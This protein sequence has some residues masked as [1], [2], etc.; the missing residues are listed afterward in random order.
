MR[1]CYSKPFL[2]FGIVSVSQEFILKKGLFTTEQFERKKIKVQVSLLLFCIFTG[3]I[4]LVIGGRL[5]EKKN[6]A[7]IYWGQAL[8]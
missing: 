6:Q 2:T 8:L 3:S 1:D 5:L 7:D 4:L